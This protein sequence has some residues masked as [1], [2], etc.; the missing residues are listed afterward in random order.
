[1]NLKNNIQRRIS[2]H[3]SRKGEKMFCNRLGCC[4][5]CNMVWVESVFSMRKHL[6]KH[7]KQG[8]ITEDEARQI[9]RSRFK[10]KSKPT[11]S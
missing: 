3:E 2:E 10:Q 5:V 6:G 8:R 7:V 9:E 1:M 4:P 11:R